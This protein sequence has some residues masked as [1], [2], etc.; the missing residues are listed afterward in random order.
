MLIKY[1]HPLPEFLLG[2]VIHLQTKGENYLDIF[3][4]QAII[5][6][7]YKD[8]CVLEIE[9]NLKIKYFPDKDF[10]YYKKPKKNIG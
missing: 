9:N 1:L 3:R 10:T 8:Y 7:V 4:F 6:E 5:K 2:K